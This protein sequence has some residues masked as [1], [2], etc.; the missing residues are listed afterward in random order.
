MWMRAI[1]NP[2]FDALRLGLAVSVLWSR[3]RRTIAMADD[4]GAVWRRK[5]DHRERGV[6]GVKATAMYLDSVVLAA[7]SVETNVR[8][9][10]TPDPRD[11]SISKRSWETAMVV[12]RRR[13]AEFVGSGGA[14]WLVDAGV[15]VEVARF[16]NICLVSALRLLGYD[17]AANRSGRLQVVGDGNTLLAPFGKHLV[18]ANLRT[19]EDGEYI[20]ATTNHVSAVR[21]IGHLG[22]LVR[23]SAP[24][25]R[26]D[27][28]ALPGV[29]GARL[30]R[31]T[32]ADEVPSTA[33]WGQTSFV[34]E[35]VH[36]ASDPR[37]EFAS[38]PGLAAE[39]AC[40]PDLMAQGCLGPSHWQ[41]DSAH[42]RRSEPH[43]WFEA[44][45]YSHAEPAYAPGFS[46]QECLGPAY[47]Q[48]D[49]FHQRGSGP[50]AW[51]ET[52]R[53]L[54]SSAAAIWEAAAEVADAPVADL[55][56]SS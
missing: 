22:W 12:W 41:R 50:D 4:A 34:S 51:S 43:D 25:E 48:H 29:E 30:F 32:P 26:V 52:R 42:Q 49:S 19:A 10:A 28:G 3:S 24:P 23:S 44:R 54:P 56:A 38:V 15:E 13:L 14:H 21:V 16:R 18:P 46:A 20:L 5:Q 45:S 8:R 17:V 40:A 11:R 35:E 33:E 7:E 6:A 37:A 39:L 2:R 31:I 9:P 36:G 1:S 47:G 55:P 27:L 53:S